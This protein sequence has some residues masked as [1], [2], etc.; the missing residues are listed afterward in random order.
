MFLFSS[1]TS[2]DGWLIS[3]CVITLIQ[4]SSTL[5]NGPTQK[6]L[7]WASCRENSVPGSDSHSPSRLGL[8]PNIIRTFQDGGQTS[9]NLIFSNISGYK[10]VNKVDVV[11]TTS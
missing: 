5:G 4:Y 7:N 3:D 10:I 11:L 1:I 8:G 2:L 9:S 6:P